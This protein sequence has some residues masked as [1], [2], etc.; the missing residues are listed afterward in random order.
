MTGQTVWPYIRATDFFVADMA[1]AKEFKVAEN[2]K[3]QFRASAFNFL[4]HALSQF[5][6]AGDVNLA[7][8]CNSTT[9]DSTM[10]VCDGGGKNTDTQTTGKPIYE[11]GHRVMEVALK[12]NF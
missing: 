11:T 3:I 9:Q 2:Q 10:P 5:G 7:M 1:L 8:A 4:N 6:L 12:Y